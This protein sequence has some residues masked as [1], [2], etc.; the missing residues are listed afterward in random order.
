[1][2]GDY[3]RVEGWGRMKWRQVREAR[4]SSMG[5]VF[6]Y[7]EDVLFCCIACLNLHMT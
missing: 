4:L 6:W 1:M 5:M 7:I 2:R 3:G